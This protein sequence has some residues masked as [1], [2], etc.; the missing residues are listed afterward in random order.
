MIRRIPIAKLLP[1]MYVVDMHRSWLAHTFWR[2]RFLVQD[3]D[4]IRRMAEEDI[5]EV[6]IDTERGRDIP[7]PPTP[8]TPVNPDYVSRAERLR[9][10]PRTLSLGEERRRAGLLLGEARHCLEDLM[11]ATRQGQTVELGRLEPLIERMIE[12]VQRNPD[13]LPPLARLKL[14]SEYAVGHALSTAA[15][16]VAYA[17]QMDLERGETENLALGTLV[18]DIGHF[19]IDAGLLGK[20]GRFSRDERSHVER[21]VEEGVSVLMAHH[22]L[23]ESALAVVLEHH[24]RFDGSGYPYHIGGTEISLAGRMA[25]VVDRFDAMVSQ[26]SYRRALIPA[27]ALGQVFAAGGQ[28]FDP[29]LL[30]AFVHA[31]GIYPVGSL[32][33]LE[34]GHLAVVEELHP[35]QLLSPVVRVIYHAGR[36]Q[37]VAPVVADLAAAVGN[38]YGQIVRAEN[39]SDWG[40][41]AV[42]WQPV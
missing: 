6:S 12:S 8:L 2:S 13:A 28:D 30:S 20:A 14:G 31:V 37:Y 16:I 21:H 41:S 9:S 40:L 4:T 42:R 5:S 26:R 1:G 17:R 25:A 7:P 3:D 24:E 29:A 19:A 15:L 39:F 33:R 10:K 36:K 32:V 27:L 38:H 22:P 11:G 23:P 34:S 18:K 35:E